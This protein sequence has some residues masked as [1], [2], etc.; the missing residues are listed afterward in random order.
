[1]SQ[2]EDYIQNLSVDN[3]E[4][5]LQDMYLVNSIFQPENEKSIKNAAFGLK[6]IIVAAILF[7]IFTIPTVDKMLT[8]ILCTATNNKILSYI[9]K[10][11]IFSALLFFITNFALSRF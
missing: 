6:D 11:V 4:P 7:A 3:Y 1:M 5:N 8:K 10:V 2:D 9:L